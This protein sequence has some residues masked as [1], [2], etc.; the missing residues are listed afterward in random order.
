M[1]LKKRNA[2]ALETNKAAS[3]LSRSPVII[4]SM[5]W[6]K[7][8]IRGFGSQVI[9]VQVRRSSASASFGIQVSHRPVSLII[10]AD[11]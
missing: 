11:N 5:R 2:C 6:W 3:L 7:R 8:L 4:T 1:T 10:S 9:I